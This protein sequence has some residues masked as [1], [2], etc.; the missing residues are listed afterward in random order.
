MSSIIASSDPPPEAFAARPVLT[1]TTG[2]GTLPSSVIPID[3]ARRRAGS[4][5]S[6]TTFRPRSAAR[7]ANAADVVVFP[8]PPEPQQT[9]MPVRGSSS[10]ASTSSDCGLV[11]RAASGPTRGWVRVISGVPATLRARPR[12]ARPPSNFVGGRSCHASVA[13]ARRELVE[14]A[15]VDALGELGQ[16]VGR[17][18]EVLDQ[19][20]LPVLQR[21]AYG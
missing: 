16:L 3:W 15:E 17:D 6:T 11:D 19:L 18:A 5:V 1:P 7:R 9:M 21:A 4:M 10:S 14:P 2:V 20:A 8:T 12:G 13:E